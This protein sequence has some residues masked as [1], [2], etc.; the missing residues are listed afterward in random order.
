MAVP[1]VFT[2]APLIPEDEV[3]GIALCDSVARTSFWRHAER[4][5]VR[6]QADKASAELKIME[7]LIGQQNEKDERKVTK[8]TKDLV[9]ER[10]EVET[11]KLS[12]QSKLDHLLLKYKSLVTAATAEYESFKGETDEEMAEVSKRKGELQA[13]FPPVSEAFSEKRASIDDDFKQAQERDALMILSGKLKGV[14]KQ[15][16]QLKVVSELTTGVKKGRAWV[17]VLVKS[18]K[19]ATQAGTRASAAKK[20]LN[21]QAATEA[22]P[23]LFKQ[24]LAEWRKKEADDINCSAN[25]SNI[26]KGS[27]VVLPP[28]RLESVATSII[29]MPYYKTQKDWVKKHIA[30]HDLTFGSA[31]IMKA[32]V[33]RQVNKYL[34]DNLEAEVHAR[35]KSGK[36]EAWLDDI[37]KKQFFLYL[38]TYAKTSVTPFCLPEARVLLE[39]ELFLAALPM[40][41]LEGET[42]AEKLDGLGGMRVDMFLEAVKAHGMCVHMLPGTSVIVPRGFAVLEL[43]VPCGSSAQGVSGVR[44]SFLSEGASITPGVAEDLS[45]VLSCWPALQSSDWSRLSARLKGAILEEPCE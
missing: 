35:L 22:L 41:S 2:L 9:V 44:W 26:K 43:V 40:S 6:Q 37:F 31:A 20:Q 28:A 36:D 19:K 5:L 45:E 27:C 16:C 30:S 21:E 15:M 33:E 12:T 18:K 29:G 25:M 10:C 4:E 24:L 39:G 7:E 1:H 8:P 34:A 11:Q 14:V 17:S 3:E 32:G 42:P 23:E 38:E 13:L